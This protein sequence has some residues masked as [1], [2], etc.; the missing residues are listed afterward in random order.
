[1]RR[2]TAHCGRL[3][4]NLTSAHLIALL[5]LFVALGGSAVAVTNIP[6]NSVGPAQLK[7]G[8]VK[9]PNIARGAVNRHKIA[10]AAVNRHKIAPRSI[11]N[12]RIAFG[13]VNGPKITNGSINRFK[14]APG[15]VDGSRLADGAVGAGALQ[16]G[17]VGRDAV[18]DGAV[19]TGKLANNSV[20]R[21]KVAEGSLPMLATL[22][23]GQT[24]RG[25][26]AVGGDGTRTVGS[27]SFAFPMRLA[28]D[29]T[30]VDATGDP[31]ASEPGCPGL[32]GGNHQT[33]Q[34]DPGMLCLYITAAS[35]TTPVLGALA[36][37][38]LGFGLEASFGDADGGTISGLWGAAAG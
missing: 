21:A 31:A 10:R 5:A 8:A 11:D 13:A 38:R 37:S 20:T 18:A 12:S 14:L 22:R 15:S 32:A 25:A 6:R 30:V 33:P 34:A 29:P 9:S 16:P 7:R 4:A 3:L 36:V 1:M 23:S 19:S 17:A 26:F 2:L 35:G 28:P 24:L 27:E